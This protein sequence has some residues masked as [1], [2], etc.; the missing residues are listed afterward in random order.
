MYFIT[1]VNIKE[2]YLLKFFIINS[3]ELI[4]NDK[5]LGLSISL[6]SLL[7]SIWIAGILHSFD[8]K[9]ET[10]VSLPA[11]KMVF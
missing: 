9:E 4:N 6:N 2:F 8:I 7:I 1:K 5:F 3:S 11:E 10:V